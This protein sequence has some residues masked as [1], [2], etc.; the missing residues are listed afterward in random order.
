ML[1][2]PVM[3]GCCNSQFL[4]FAETTVSGEHAEQQLQA[5]GQREESCSEHDLHHRL[6]EPGTLLPGLRPQTRTTQLTGQCMLRLVA[7]LI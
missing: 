4:R 1:A 2:S 6:L 3:H 7:E 5:G